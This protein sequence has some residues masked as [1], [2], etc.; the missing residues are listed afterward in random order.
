MKH[1]IRI[2]LGVVIV[3]VCASAQSKTGTTVGQFLL[4]EPSARVAA[5]GN[6]ASTSYDEVTAAYYNPGAIGHFTGMGV[7]FTHSVWLADIA[8]NYGAVGLSMGDVGNVYLSVTS[9]NS[10]EIAVRT[11]EQPY[12][13][14]EKYTVADFAIGLGYGRR[15][16]ERFSVGLQVNYMQE[17]IWHSSLSAFALNVGTIYTISPNGLQ[18]GASISNFGTRARYQGRDLR[19][20]YDPNPTEHGTNSSLP[21]EAYTETYPLPVLF[22]VG[23]C[24]PFQFSETNKVEL[25]VNAL[26][27]SDN[28]ESMSMG[29]EWRFMNVFAVRA[30]YQNLFMQDSETGLTLGAG[31]HFDA[32]DIIFRFDY[33][34]A[35]QGRLES[36]HRFTLGVS[37]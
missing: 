32:N 8:Y 19:I 17:T 34:W 18:I 13:T 9:L 21:G 16:S 4:I 35:D 6:A 22:R 15:I 23:V 37:F 5:L 12:G 31:L 33:A 26:H 30:G 20:T 10:G 25:M 36:S 28:T 3:S 24:M 2:I 1:L 11:V 14:G 27:P 7:Q 29:A